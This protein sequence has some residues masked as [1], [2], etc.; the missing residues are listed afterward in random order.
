MR[1]G[2]GGV[3]RACW[4]FVRHGPSA[5]IRWLR[6]NS[7]RT[8]TL[9]WLGGMGT[10]VVMTVQR[11]TGI[12]HA[13]VAKLAADREALRVAEAEARVEAELSGRP[14]PKAV[15]PA[16][17]GPGAPAGGAGGA[18]GP[19]AAVAAQPSGAGGRDETIVLMDVDE[20]EKARGGSD[21]A[22]KEA[23]AGLAEEYEGEDG[24]AEGDDP[25]G[26]VETVAVQSGK[27]GEGVNVVMK[28]GGI[29]GWIRRNQKYR[30]RKLGDKETLEVLGEVHG[31]HGTKVSVNPDSPLGG[32]AAIAAARGSA[33]AEEAETGTKLEDGNRPAEGVL[34]P[35]VAAPA[36]RGPPPVRAAGAAA[37]AP[38]GATS[39][40]AP[41]AARGTAATADPGSPAPA[42]I[43]PGP[44]AP[45]PIAPSPD[46]RGAAD[47]PVAPAGTSLGQA[48]AFAL[49]SAT[50]RPPPERASVASPDGDREDD[51]PDFRSLGLAVVIA[52]S[53]SL[54]SPSAL[55]PE[56]DAGR[57][58]PDAAVGR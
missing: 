49:S 48:F 23:V 53:E 29:A 1:S 52:I 55:V 41:V 28:K 13:E 5:V 36:T 4:R 15:V 16:A 54:A 46:P 42:R 30:K 7:S 37:P 34:Q 43:A 47:R 45:G 58:T 40:A 44:I 14:L 3:L 24:G 9:L 35:D 17:G 11:Y 21:E 56:R 50:G 6:S 38:A 10:F 18:G 2:I 57:S 22:S 25:D 20:M 31:G 8:I 51:G 32:L 12:R 27:P 33:V 39:A 26:G 19:E